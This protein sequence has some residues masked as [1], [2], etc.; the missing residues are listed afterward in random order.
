LFYVLLFFISLQF[1]INS[2]NGLISN[3]AI[4]PYILMQK[5]THKINVP[6][7]V[8][9]VFQYT[10]RLIYSCL[11]LF[12]YSS[13]F[14]ILPN[15]RITILANHNIKEYIKTSRKFIAKRVGYI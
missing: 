15:R 11:Y 3:M 8:L 2:F 1:V 10:K 13:L 12:F 7:E 9:C 5:A 4:E 14:I 6:A